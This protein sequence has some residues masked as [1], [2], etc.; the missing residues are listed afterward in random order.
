ME[1]DAHSI[2]Q[3]I[4]IISPVAPTGSPQ[5]PAWLM[6]I[7]A[8]VVCLGFWVIWRWYQ[9]ERQQILRRLKHLRTAYKA[10][11]L[12]T[13]DITYWLADILKRRL[14]INHLS[15][16]IT[17]PSALAK[18]Q[19]RW[20]AFLW[21]LHQTRYAPVDCSEQEIRYLLAET[22]YWLRRWP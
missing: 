4:D 11:E 10:C 18:E 22:C 17:L 19:G 1:E 6:I 9:S 20:K 21:H 13:S 8:S 16:E 15:T 5:T 7:V 2:S 3:L 12:P 14:R